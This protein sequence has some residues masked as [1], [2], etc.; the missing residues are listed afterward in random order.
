MSKIYI[1]VKNGL[2]NAVYT[3]SKKELE[4]ILCDYDNAKQEI[5]NDQFEFECTNNIKELDENMEHLHRI[6]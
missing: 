3:D 4:V 2:V 1:E 5:G 6:F